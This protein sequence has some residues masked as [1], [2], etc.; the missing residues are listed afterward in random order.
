MRQV[1]PPGHWYAADWI[2]LAVIA[3]AFALAAG[4]WG[5]K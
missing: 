3:L 5:F 4:V 2:W 1:T